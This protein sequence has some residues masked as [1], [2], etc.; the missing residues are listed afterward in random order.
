MSGLC[1]HSILSNF[2]TR[3]RS[4]ARLQAPQTLRG[5]SESAQQTFVTPRSS[6]GCRKAQGVEHQFLDY[7]EATM[8]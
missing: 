8:C 5:T 6:L 1:F 4:L 7:L 2:T 3:Q